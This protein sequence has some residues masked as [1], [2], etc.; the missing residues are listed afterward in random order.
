MEFHAMVQR[1][2]GEYLD[3]PGLNLTVPQA[4]RRWGLDTAACNRVLGVLI[5]ASFLRRTRD[6]RVV[7]ADRSDV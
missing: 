6:G 1:A 2:R 4:A 5:C 3:M 7:R